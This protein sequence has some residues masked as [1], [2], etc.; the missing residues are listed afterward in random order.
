MELSSP[1]PRF[2]G[3]GSRVKSSLVEFDLTWAPGLVDPGL[4]WALHPQDDEPALFRDGFEPVALFSFRRCRAEIEVIGAS[5]FFWTPLVWL[6]RVG[7]GLLVCSSERVWL[8][9][10]VTA[11]KSLTGTLGGRCS[12]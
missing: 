11:Q 12:L 5:A 9:Y 4:E 8:S 7:Y 3:V 1:V 6:P 10:T 2:L